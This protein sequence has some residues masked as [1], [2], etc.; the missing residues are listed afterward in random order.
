MTG[1]LREGVSIVAVIAAM[2][3]VVLD[4]GLINVALPT[5]AGALHVTSSQAILAV[6]AYQAALVMGLLPAAHIA[7]RIGLKALF[8]R[9]LMLFSVSSILCGLAPSLTVLLVAR[10][11][12]GLGGAAIMA[13]GIALLRVASGTQ[14]LGQVIGW[15]ALNV[16][17]C[18]ATGPVLGALILSVAPWPWLFFAKLPLIAI[19]SAA[20]FA[21]PRDQSARRAIDHA[22]IGLHASVV[23]L[24][25]VAACAARTG[26]AILAGLAVFALITVMTRRERTRPAPLWPIDLLSQRAFRVSVAASVCC[27]IAQS[28]GTLALPLYVQLGL[29]HGPAGAAL[30]LTCWPLAVAI[31]STAASRLAE[32][33]GSARQCV[34]GGV[35][36]ALGLAFSALWPVGNSAVPLAVGAAMSGLGFGLFQVSNNRT[37]FLSAAPERSAA[38]GGLQ[39]SARLAGQTMGAFAMGML[40]TGFD[41]E[42]AIRLGLAIG[43][44]FALFAALISATGVPVRRLAEEI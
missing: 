40:L 43:A 3:L 33:F 17:L 26:W 19:A 31:T 8:L 41:A 6:S 16:A 32:R 37:M 38:A 23:A 14:G 25:L 5:I 29:G 28:A 15:N 11:A 36:L 2:S 10:V 42:L 39:G 44:M 27:F 7:E 21:L 35:I 24:F 12:Q 4:A 18:S 22:G 9:G 1:K 34:T 13:L 20:A 30:V